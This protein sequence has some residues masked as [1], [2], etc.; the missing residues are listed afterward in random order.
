[1]TG[2]RSPAMPNNRLIHVVEM[3]DGRRNGSSRQPSDNGHIMAVSLA[4][5]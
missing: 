3:Y 5:S 1:M 2:L 4:K